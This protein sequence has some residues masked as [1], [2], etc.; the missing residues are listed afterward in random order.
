MLSAVLDISF[1]A[2]VFL[3]IY[4]TDLKYQHISFILCTLLYN[5]G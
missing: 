5:V 3:F 1:K 4:G 2:E